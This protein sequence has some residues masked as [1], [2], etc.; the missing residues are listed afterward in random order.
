[1][2]CGFQA[3]RSHPQPD[4]DLHQEREQAERQQAK[5][6]LG[7]HRGECP[8]TQTATAS[9]DYSPGSLLIVGVYIDVAPVAMSFRAC[10]TGR[11]PY[12]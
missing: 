6:D 8:A 7:L 2:G 11:F 1:L 3:T 10:A 12:L 4:E 5:Q 9:R